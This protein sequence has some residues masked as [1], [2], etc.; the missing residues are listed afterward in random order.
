LIKKIINNISPSDKFI[1]LFV[2]KAVGLYLLWYLVYDNWLVTS[3]YVD[4]LLIDQLVSATDSILRFLGYTT[5]TYADA[6]GVD[7]THGVL[8]GV[9]C[10]GLSLFALFAGFIIVFPGK[11]LHKLI[12]IP[13]GILVVHV[14][15][16]LRLVG[17]A[18]IVVYDSESLAFN[19]KY[20][21]TII[22]YAC[23]FLMWVLWVKKFATKSNSTKNEKS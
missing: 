14:L 5:F 1:A 22:V 17:L 2:L 10:N 21:F 23:I 8:I 3:G 9:P 16:I 13:L 11:I 12:Y 7:G 6:V 20:T 4:H 18:L 15:N 19:H